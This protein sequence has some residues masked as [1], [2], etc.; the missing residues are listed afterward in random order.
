MNAETEEQMTEQR[1]IIE[2]TEL[3]TRKNSI[4]SVPYSLC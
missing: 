2:N 1:E 4:S 3:E